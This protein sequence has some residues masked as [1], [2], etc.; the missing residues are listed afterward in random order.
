MKEEHWIYILECRDGSFY[1]GYTLDPVRRYREHLSSKKKAKY[2]RGFSPVR[3]AGCWK[4]KEPKGTALRIEHMIK[5][6]GRAFKENIL[7]TP[8]L[9]KRT[10]DTEYEGDF[11]IESY[12]TEAVLKECVAD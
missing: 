6:K 11:R 1:T 7:E 8:D 12:D 4:V 9:L 10:F 3:M 5:K 2:T